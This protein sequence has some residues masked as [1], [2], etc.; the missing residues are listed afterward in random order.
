MEEVEQEELFPLMN[1][2]CQDIDALYKRD[3]YNIGVNEGRAAVVL[4][5]S[6]STRPRKAFPHTDCVGFVRSVGLFDAKY[7][8]E[9]GVEDMLSKVAPF[10]F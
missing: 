4:D 1:L 6:T 10:S 8:G 3:G 7:P 9:P 5:D 2:E